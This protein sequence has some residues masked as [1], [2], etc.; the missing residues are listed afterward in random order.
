[1]TRHGN[2]IPGKIIFSFNRKVDF[3]RYFQANFASVIFIPYIVG[4]VSPPLSLENLGKI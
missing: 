4:I 3:Q 1:M 2:L